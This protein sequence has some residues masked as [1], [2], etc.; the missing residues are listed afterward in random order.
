MDMDSEER[1]SIEVLF[2]LKKIKNLSYYHIPSDIIEYKR[3]IPQNLRLEQMPF[4]VNENGVLKYL[5]KQF[6]IKRLET[7]ARVTATFPN[8]PPKG[9]KAIT[10]DTYKILNPAFENLLKKF[11]TKFD[12][13]FKYLLKRNKVMGKTEVNK[14]ITRILKTKKLGKKEKLLLKLLSNLEPHQISDLANKTDSKAIKKIKATLQEKILD[15]GLKIST[16]KGY[17]LNSSYYQLEY[18][19]T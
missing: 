11:N 1:F 15:S 18:L 4:P 8:E 13:R 2:V 16:I 17:G 14:I 3:F 6:V 12:R 10:F 9:V 7:P 5:E 19:P